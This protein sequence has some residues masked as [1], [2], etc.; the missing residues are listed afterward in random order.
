[1]SKV[2]TLRKLPLAVIT[3]H[4]KETFRLVYVNTDGFQTNTKLF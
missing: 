4:P 1:M 2:F 3:L